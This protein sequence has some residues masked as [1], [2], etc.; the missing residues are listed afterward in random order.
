MT[1]LRVLLV[2]GNGFLGR[3]AAAAL[4]ERADLLA[5]LDR[6]GSATAHRPGMPPLPLGVQQYAGSVARADDITEVVADVRPNVIASLAAF[7]VRDLGL[8]P[9]AEQDPAGAIDINVVG[10]L[11][12]LQVA[13]ARPG[14]RVLWTSSTTVYGRAAEYSEQFVDEHSLLCPRSVYAASKV[15]GEQL[16]R[17][18]RSRGEVEAVALRPTLVWG[19]GIRYRGVQSALS[20]MVEAVA[21]GTRARVPGS[22]E[23]WDLLYVRDAG[24]AV[25]W[26][27]Q[28]ADPDETI[29]VNGFRASVLDVRAALLAER[30]GASIEFAG[31]SI[32]LGFPPVDDARAR[33]F[34]FAPTYDLRRSIAD[35]LE[36][37]KQSNN[38]E[39]NHDATVPNS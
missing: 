1:G 39:R 11:N 4:A 13:A 17:S 35:Y 9:S 18:F 21:A 32:R 29:L 14:T 3:Y 28:A 34:G 25:A 2:G 15:L 5:I 38:D 8:V 33:K 20:D 6:A 22:D 24:R 31:E 27:V 12:V 16:I 10:L 23:T 7:G 19:P 30:P 26:F 36:V 37:V